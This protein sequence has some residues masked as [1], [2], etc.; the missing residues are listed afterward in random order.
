MVHGLKRH[1]EGLVGSFGREARAQCGSTTECLQP[2]FHALECPSFYWDIFL[3]ENFLGRFSFG[4]TFWYTFLLG[5]FFETLFFWET[6]W[7]TV[8][9]TF[10]LG[11]ILGHFFGKLFETVF[12]EH[13]RVSTAGVSRT[14]ILLTT[15]PKSCTAPFS[16]KTHNSPLES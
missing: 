12:W 7:N 15:P 4:K 6:F 1:R 14:G 9:Y 2:E 16:K 10:L 5:N 8:W 11:N 3:L 13:D